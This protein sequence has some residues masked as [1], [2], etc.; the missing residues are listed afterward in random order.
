MALSITGPLNV[1]FRLKMNSSYTWR[2]RVGLTGDRCGDLG[3][4]YTW[5]CVCACAC[6]KRKINMSSKYECFPLPRPVTHCPN[7]KRPLD[8]ELLL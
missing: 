4:I 5:A 6:V 7:E 2:Q 8:A 3:P 1:C